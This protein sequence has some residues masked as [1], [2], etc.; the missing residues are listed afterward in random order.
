MDKSKHQKKCDHI[1]DLLSKMRTSMII[2]TG[3]NPS[4]FYA[5]LYCERCED[6]CFNVQI[7]NYDKTAKQ[8]DFG[9]DLIVTAARNEEEK[10]IKGLS[11]YL[12]MK[13][14]EEH[15]AFKET[16]RNCSLEGC[17]NAVFRGKPLCVPPRLCA[18]CKAKNV[19]EKSEVDV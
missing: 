16:L 10:D 7:G 8:Y 6:W 13:L 5:D 19:L 2:F 18:H 17:M 1:K 11:D 15:K 3:Q 4:S 14:Y 12:N 9:A